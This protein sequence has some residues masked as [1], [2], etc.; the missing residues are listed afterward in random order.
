MQNAGKVCVPTI[1]LKEEEE[2]DPT[3]YLNRGWYDR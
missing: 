1:C 2:E 3:V